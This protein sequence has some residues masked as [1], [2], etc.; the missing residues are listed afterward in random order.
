LRWLRV[1]CL[2]SWG[3]VKAVFATVYCNE[4]ESMSRGLKPAVVARFG[5]RD[6]SRTYLRSN[7]KGNSNG[8]GNSN[9]NG[10][11]NSNSRSPAGMTSQKGKSKG[12]SNGNSGSPAGM[13]SQKG[14]SKTDTTSLYTYGELL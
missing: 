4:K 9:S 10:N 11:G 3:L 5:V 7:S 14:N 8:N 12:N 13:T 2:T 6:K 1:F